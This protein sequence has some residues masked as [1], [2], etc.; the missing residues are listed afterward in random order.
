MVPH[1]GALSLTRVLALTLACV[2][3]WIAVPDAAAEAVDSELILLVD[4]SSGGLRDDEFGSLM[5]AYA[6]AMTSA[7]VLD[8]IQSGARGQ[9]AASL[10]F[11]NTRIG[12]MVGVPWMTIGSA[13]EARQFADAVLALARPGNGPAS[14]L[15]A[16]TL[17]ASGMSALSHENNGYES[18]LQIIEVAGA[19]QVASAELARFAALATGTDQINAITV[20]RHAER[21]ESFYAESVVG[22]EVE[23]RPA[24]SQALAI[25][26]IL[27]AALASRIT[28]TDS[29]PPP[30]PIPEPGS[31]LLLLSGLGG[32]LL[33]RRRRS[34]PNPAQP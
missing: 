34:T 5:E 13:A 7:D 2:A 32:L 9:I 4:V 22:G 8:S 20:G 26:A 17:I 25:D 11:F 14:L 30:A 3:S 29:S 23:G 16:M 27:P 6:T 31:G 10:F 1:R 12:D 21:L 15:T 19:S 33:V 18:P 24:T 28:A